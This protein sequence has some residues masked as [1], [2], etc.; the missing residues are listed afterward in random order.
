MGLTVRG[1]EYFYAMVKDRPGEAHRIFSLLARE[2]VNLLAFSALP[3]GPGQTQLILFPE[4]TEQILRATEITGL[5][6]IGPQRAFVIQG[7][8]QLGALADIHR[9]LADALVNVYGSMG[10]SDGRG[11]YGY[12]LYV[13]PD[14][15]DNAAEILGVE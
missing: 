11:G 12:V 15:Y 6:L 8:D 14:D 2:D 10:I 5:V 4:E 7:D 13:R 1:I 9:K 3:I